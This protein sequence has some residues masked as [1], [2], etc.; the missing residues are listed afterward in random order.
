MRTYA[1]SIRA[2]GL[3]LILALFPSFAATN[4]SDIW[5]NPRES[6]WGLTVADHETTMWAIWFTYRQNG[7]PTWMYVPGGTFS[8]DKRNFTGDIYQTTGPSWRAA[9]ASK[10]ITNVK[11]GTASFDFTPPGFA[12][13]IALFTYTVGEVTGSKQIERFG[14]GNAAPAWGTDFTDV[15][16]DPAES[17][18]GITLAQHGSTVF[19]VW[20]TYGDDGLPLFV[21]LPS[22]ALSG[23]DTI[24]GDLITTT[25][26]WFGNSN[27]NSAQVTQARFGTLEATIEIR[28]AI[29]AKAF[30]PM[31]GSW[32]PRHNDGTSFTKFFTQLGFGNAAPGTAPPACLITNTCVERTSSSGDSCSY[33]TCTAG[34]PNDGYDGYGYPSGGMPCSCSPETNNLNVPCTS[35][36]P[37]V[38]IGQS[39]AAG[40][41]C[42]VGSVCATLNNGLKVCMGDSDFN[43]NLCY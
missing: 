19:G 42:A 12:P 18:W 26:P 9:Y 34:T 4:Y 6:G 20:Y 7:T 10:P 16:W 25:G 32:R 8:N 37:M 33:R 21:V 41:G 28:P 43:R 14:F 30:R 1:A 17:G 11:V 40:Q 23:T 29:Q 22:G 3:G 2:L 38:A 5:W 27:F 39:C 31:K 13:G 15:W 24:R 36:R 35:S